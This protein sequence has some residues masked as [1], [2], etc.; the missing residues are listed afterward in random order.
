MVTKQM[1]MYVAPEQ[2]VYGRCAVL[3]G[4]FDAVASYQSIGSSK[5]VP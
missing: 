1:E 5:A 3:A 2:D 4:N